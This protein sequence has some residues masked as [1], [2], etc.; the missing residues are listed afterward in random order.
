MPVAS[1]SVLDG[2]WARTDLLLEEL[3][4][5]PLDNL[6]GAFLLGTF[7][8]L[9]L[10]GVSVAQVYH[11]WPTH[12]GDTNFI[13]S[14][15][16]TVMLLETSHAV[17][18]MHTC[19]F[20]LVMHYDDPHRVGLG[21]WSL[22]VTPMVSSFITAACQIFFARRVYLIAP[23]YK[24]LVV[25]ASIALLAHVG[26][27]MGIAANAFEVG[28][29]SGFQGNGD[30]LFPAVLTSA[31]IAD[32]LL[33]AGILHAVRRSRAIHPPSQS[34]TTLDSVILYVV[35]SGIL[36]GVV[37]TA[38]TIAA[39]TLPQTF[40][41]AGLSFVGTRFY[42]VTLLSVLNSRNLHASRGMEIF[43]SG[44]PGCNSIAR[45]NHLVTAERWNAPQAS[46]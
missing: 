9:V 13:Q 40:I 28:S 30:W 22:Q 24:I 7:V 34:E 33:S 16:A 14:L 45:A 31:I 27:S 3:L 26:F 15:V 10:Y 46:D 23:R 29:L 17:L 32:F 1:L 5:P 43:L 21:V 35:N 37:N 25:F 2:S 44:P 38:P 8:S 41:W 18:L 11:Y 42:A 12:S 39:F 4:P 36:T 19:Y 6:Y 20:Y